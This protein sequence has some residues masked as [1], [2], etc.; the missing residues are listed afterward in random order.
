MSWSLDEPTTVFLTGGTGLIGAAVAEALGGRGHEVFLLVREKSRRSAETW[1]RELRKTHEAARKRIVLLGGDLEQP[2]ILDQDK[3]R[4]RVVS[5][6]RVMI[7]CGAA[8]HLAVDAPTAQAVNVQGTRHV[9]ALAGELT[10][11][12]R[13]VHFSAAAVAGDH[14]GRV[15]EDDLQLGQRFYNH[16]AES[17]HQAEVLVREVDLPTTILRPS[18]VVG[19]RQTG[20]IGKVDGV[21]HL[22]LLLLRVASLP[23]P[24]RVL[25]AAP[26]GH[27]AHIDLVPLDWLVD[28]A[29]ALASHDD[30]VGGS[31][32]LS[33][34]RAL[35]VRQLAKL[36]ASRLG[37]AGPFFSLP[38]R[39][40]AMLLRSN[41]DSL[42]RQL[43]DQLLSL[44]PELADG[45]AHRARYDT[46]NAQRLLGPLGLRAPHVADY[47]D[48][49]LTFARDRLL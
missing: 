42:A 17:K 31:F 7:H 26:G 45:L 41:R 12:Q 44:P 5:E 46:T 38:G 37:I 23:R 13:F 10:D 3:H 29:L 4:Q 21:Y 32:H 43:S 18:Q 39:P 6:A 2:A 19:D 24:L 22:I 49:L 11:L 27:T 16:W 25:P 1:L 9:L 48:P 34:P 8:M 33:D 40:L 30:A 15:G 47:V 36:F 14:E 28:A 35:T 20:A